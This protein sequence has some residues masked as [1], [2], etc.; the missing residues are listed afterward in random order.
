MYMCVCVCV[1]MCVGCT[2]TYFQIA[3]VVCVAVFPHHFPHFLLSS[4][5]MTAPATGPF[6]YV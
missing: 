1:C 3:M 5:S 2:L 6:H 4:M